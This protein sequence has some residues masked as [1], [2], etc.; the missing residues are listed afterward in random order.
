V[1][2]VDLGHYRSVR[3]S[4]TEVSSVKIFI[5]SDMEGTATSSDAS[6]L[7]HTYFPGAIAEVSI[8]GT[9][10]GESGINALVAKAHEVPVVLVTGDETTA[11]E[12]AKFCPGARTAIVKKS[13]SRYAAE[14]LHPPDGP[15]L[16]PRAGLPGHQGGGVGAEGGDR[17]ARHRRSPV[18]DQ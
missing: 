14:S 4:P 8:N 11:A 6:T 7:S 12:A 15:D 18:P 1:D 2:W 5:S 13:I 16:D 10:A 3:L 9:I 17:Y